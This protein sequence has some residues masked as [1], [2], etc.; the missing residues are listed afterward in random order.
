MVALVRDA[1][2]G[3]DTEAQR[4]VLGGTAARLWFGDGS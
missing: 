3:L 4:A 1:V 2:A